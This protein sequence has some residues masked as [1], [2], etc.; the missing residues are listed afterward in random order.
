MFIEITS[1]ER[2]DDFAVRAAP[3][4]LC[5]NLWKSNAPSGHFALMEKWVDFSNA[6][7][8]QFLEAPFQ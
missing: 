6:V 3:E 4:V 1:L 8:G 2:E 5:F 7:F